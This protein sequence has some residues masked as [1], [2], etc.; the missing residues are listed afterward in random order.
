V[1]ADRLGTPPDA[2][3]GAEEIERDLLRALATAY[4]VDALV[5]WE[6]RIDNLPPS[7]SSQKTRQ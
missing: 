1:T 7:P 4:V 2:G 5:G 3:F 6:A